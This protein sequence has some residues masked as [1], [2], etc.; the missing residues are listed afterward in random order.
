MARVA[1]PPARCA[2]RAVIAVRGHRHYQPCALFPCMGLV[3]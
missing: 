3:A 2:Y 1:R